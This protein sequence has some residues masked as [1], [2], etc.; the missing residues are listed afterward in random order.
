VALGYAP[1]GASGKPRNL[2]QI[3]FSD[4]TGTNVWRQY[5]AWPPKD[6]ERKTL[7][8][9]ANGGLSF[10]APSVGRCIR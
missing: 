6:V 3:R 1:L 5:S 7:Y 8:F 4:T 9:H 2:K 10:D